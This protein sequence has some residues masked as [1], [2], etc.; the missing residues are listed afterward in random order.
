M[1]HTQKGQKQT[2]WTGS[3]NISSAY[4]KAMP[5]LNGTSYKSHCSY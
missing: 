2:A 3:Q 1:V 4:A 5:L